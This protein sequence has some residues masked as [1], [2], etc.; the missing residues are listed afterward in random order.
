MRIFIGLEKV[1]EILKE[2]GL[3]RNEDFKIFL[4]AE[5]P[6]NIILADKFNKYIDGF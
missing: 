6:S 1:L 3:E 2:N 5:I 4:M